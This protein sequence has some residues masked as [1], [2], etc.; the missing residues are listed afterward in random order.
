MVQLLLGSQSPRR[1]ALLGLTGYRFT[2]TAADVDEE[3]ITEADP[4]Q[5]ALQTALL[6]AKWLL[7][8]TESAPEQ[9]LLI[10]AD[11]TVALDE[12]L[13]GKP[14]NGRE[15]TD[16]LRVLHGRTHQVHTGVTVV[17]LQTGVLITGV[18]SAAVAMRAYSDEEIRRYVASGDPLDKAGAYAIQHPEFA[19]VGELSGCYLGVVGLSIC[20]LLQ[21]LTTLGLQPQVDLAALGA[22]HSG[23]PC[24]LLANAARKLGK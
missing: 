19:P 23:Y 1:R 17:D 4:A 18:H 9:R 6:K 13:L 22:A 16:M 5:N 14:S 7:A 20:H 2:A 11:T 15:A 10:T 21:L 8:R 12:K 24:P 3:S